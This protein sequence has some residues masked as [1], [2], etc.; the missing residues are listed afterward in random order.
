M[1][2]LDRFDALAK[3]ARQ[4]PIPQCDISHIVIARLQRDGIAPVLSMQ[5]FAL[6]AV[7]SA[8]TVA[9][10]LAIVALLASGSSADSSPTLAILSSY[11]LLWL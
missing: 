10:V 9:A 6:F 8:A 4:E 3:L 2:A 7:A 5:R 1:D 11:E